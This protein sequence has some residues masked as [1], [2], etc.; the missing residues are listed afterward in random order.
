MA[1]AS[2][3]QTH[4][5]QIELVDKLVRLLETLRDH[6]R[7]LTLQELAAKTG[8]VKSSIHRALQS[9]RQHGYIEQSA[10]GAYALGVQFLLLAR[11]LH[12]GIGLIA[13]ARPHLRELVDTFD[14]S[15]YLAIL[16]GG[17]GVFVEVA[18]TRRR[19]L[20]L[21]GPLG[22]TVH[23]H[24]T[25][26][27]K[28]MA[29]FLPPEA[30]AGLLARTRPERVTV[31]TRTRRADVE[32]DWATTRRRGYATNDEETIVGA[33]FIAAPV[34]DAEQAVCGSIS[35]GI[36]KPRYAPALG[37][38][39]AAQLTATCQRLSDTLRAAGYVHEH[40]ELHELK[41]T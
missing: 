21:V 7:G 34:F 15:A 36:P 35:V 9:L 19:E 20:R 29:A 25:A 23:F 18:E 3:P 14:E 8:Y 31:R 1:P 12:E 10:A 32:R 2:G 5:Y 33:I 6:P 30:Q 37:R 17:H 28:A 24:A 40:R 11:G 41:R 16:R 4:R 26:A 39:I 22:A 13:Y 38:R 27:G